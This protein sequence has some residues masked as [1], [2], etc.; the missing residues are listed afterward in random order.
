MIKKLMYAG[1]AAAMFC[2][3]ACSFDDDIALVVEAESEVSF[4]VELPGN[5]ESRTFNDGYSARN[6]IPTPSRPS[7]IAMK[8]P[9]PWPAPTTK[10]WSTCSPEQ[11][12]R[13]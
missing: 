11:T 10:P 2:T 6:P 13:L 8:K 4:T 12:N 1:C 3:A 9:S 5:L 7:P